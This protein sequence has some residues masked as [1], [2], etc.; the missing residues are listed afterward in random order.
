MKK[1]FALVAVFFVLFLAASTITPFFTGNTYTVILYNYFND[2]T[3]V[4]V[5]IADESI[6]R[7]KEIDKQKDFSKIT[8]EALKEGDTDVNIGD[9]SFDTKSLPV[10]NN[11]LPPS[12][13]HVNKFNIIFADNNRINFNDSGL[14]ILYFTI[15]LLITMSIIIFS[16][17]KSMKKTI[18]S[19]TNMI[20]FGLLFFFVHLLYS[21]ILVLL[22]YFIY[23]E[24]GLLIDLWTNI[25]YSVENLRGCLVI[26]IALIFLLI[27][28][29]NISL[30]IHE[31]KTWR[32]MLGVILGIAFFIGSIIFMPFSM[33][34]GDSLEIIKLR[35]FSAISVNYCISAIVSYL[36]CMLLGAIICALIAVF[37]KP[38][39]DK[40]F[41]IILGCG[42]KKDGTL[43]P[44]L[45]GR[46]DRAIT[47]ARK[48][49]ETTGKDICFVPSGGQGSDEIISESQAMKNYL[50]SQG[51]DEDHIIMED[52]SSTTLENMKFSKKIINKINPN[53]KIIFS[54]TNYHI[55]RSGMLSQAAELNA[56]GIG[57]KTKWYFWPNAFLREF[58]GIICAKIKFHIFAISVII[59]SILSMLALYY[60]VF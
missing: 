30:I 45:K 11:L 7:L 24:S 46:V 1:A 5:S 44:L 16:L 4:K 18:Y 47:F 57:S 60:F 10:L 14:I 17:V 21:S 51:I 41:V 26:P 55:F 40:D 48:Q 15:F 22:H 43:L 38:K 32:N 29:S 20:C 37:K 19:Y 23:Q 6:V 34:T 52:K 49:K 58:V 36:D 8:F 39:Y 56:E 12:S 13:F 42:I 53:A 50:L 2:S 25:L 33:S 3:D 54:T 35:I 59:L 28:I 27:S 31:G 9:Y